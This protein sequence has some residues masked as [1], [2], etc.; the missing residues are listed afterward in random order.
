MNDRAF[1]RGTSAW[2]TAKAMRWTWR[3]I[4]T[5]ETAHARPILGSRDIS[6][7]RWPSVWRN[8][9]IQPLSRSHS[10]WDIPAWRFS[11]APLEAA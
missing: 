4:Q 3:V 7:P 2:R 8:A 10:A 9:R 6:T 5:N 11:F 1:R